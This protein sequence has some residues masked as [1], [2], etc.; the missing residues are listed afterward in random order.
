MKSK[1]PKIYNYQ[2]LRFGEETRPDQPK[3]NDEEKDK[4]KDSDNE[5]EKTQDLVRFISINFLY[6]FQIPRFPNVQHHFS[7]F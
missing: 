6:N 3:D 4:D 5:K 7:L 1:L 2:I